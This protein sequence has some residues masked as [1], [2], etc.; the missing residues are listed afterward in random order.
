MPTWQPNWEDVDFD[1]EAAWAAIAECHSAAGALDTGF[2]GFAAAV[3][4]LETD[5]AWVGAYRLDF[6][7]ARA[8][9]A[10]DAGATAD[11]LRTLAGAIEDAIYEAASEQAHR[12]RERERWH[13]EK[14]RED[15]AR[16]SPH[17]I[18]L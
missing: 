5:G 16:V 2:T 4:A 6:D 14:A 9:V 18:P 15:A 12:E 17:P 3:S 11:E 7:D 8:I 10:T 1:Y 13:E